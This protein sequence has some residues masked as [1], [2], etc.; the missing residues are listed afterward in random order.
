MLVSLLTL[1]TVASVSGNSLGYWCVKDDESVDNQVGTSFRG[2]FRNF[3]LFVEEKDAMLSNCTVIKSYVLGNDGLWVVEESSAK[4]VENT[5]G[6]LLA[7]GFPIYFEKGLSFIVGGGAEVPSASGLDG[8]GA[9]LDTAFMPVASRT[10]M[11]PK[12]SVQRL[13]EWHV[14]SLLLNPEIENA[15]SSVTEDSLTMTIEALQA[16]NTRNSFSDT[17]YGEIFCF[18][19]FV[20]VKC[21]N[22]LY[23]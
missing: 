12:L 2:K 17:I 15:V 13:S 18:F 10:V 14:P 19:S 22:V 23:L 3:S 1:L 20:Q 11:H 5:K 8:C 7:R 4:A 6:K 16:L 21:H 9:D